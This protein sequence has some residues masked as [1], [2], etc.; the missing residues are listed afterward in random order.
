[1][2][3]WNVV[4]KYP[5]YDDEN[6]ISHTE[7]V[8]AS[9]SSGYATYTERVLGNQMAKTDAELVELAREAH[10]KGEYADRAMA[11]S[12]Q[13]VDELKRRSAA[14]EKQIAD[15]KGEIETLKN[16]VIAEVKSETEKNREMVKIVTMTVNELLSQLDVNEESLDEAEPTDEQIEE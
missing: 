16:E 4:G 14:F 5:I 7:I 3:N 11:E 2:R 8:I 10:F 15:A 12:V 9:T 1:M 6:K 13:T